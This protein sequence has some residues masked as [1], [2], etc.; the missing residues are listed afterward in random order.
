MK[1]IGAKFKPAYNYDSD[2]IM[3]LPIDQFNKYEKVE[4]K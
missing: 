3:V 4:Y 2:G 1:I